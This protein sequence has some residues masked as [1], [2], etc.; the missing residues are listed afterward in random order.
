MALAKAAFDYSN[1][2]EHVRQLMSKYQIDLLFI[3]PSASLQYLTGLK[4]HQPTYGNVNY[5][6]GWV[7]GALFGQNKAPILSL[8]RMATLF[9]SFPSNLE[10]AILQDTAD[11][12]A[13]MRKLL[14]SFGPIKRLAIEERTWGSAILNLQKLLP[15]VEFVSA[16]PLLT[17]LRRAKSPAEIE[18]MRKAAKIID[19]THAHIVPM[20]R[21]GVTY[22]EVSAEIDKKMTELGAEAQSFPTTLI[23][24]SP[25]IGPGADPWAGSANHTNGSPIIEAG[26]SLSFD[27]GS[28][29][30]G[31][32]NDYGR[33]VWIGEPPA[34]YLKI[35]DLVIG[36]QAAARKAMKA[37][38][39]TGEAANTVA[40]EVI[41]GSGYGEYFFHRLGH[42]IGLDVH[43]PCYLSEGDTT[44]LQA[45]MTFT[46]EP[47]IFI[48]GKFGARIE[49][50]F[51]VTENGAE[52]LNQYPRN[53]EVVN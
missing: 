43:E 34:E 37:G 4:R 48:P 13:H 38:T 6:G 50:V 22:L 41:D 25:R 53:L 44:L 27:Y 17:E 24:M 39:I 18:L 29:F 47:S 5:N 49:D 20:L 26:T 11:P 40:R 52:P 28:V 31:Y 12:E 3:P 33:S 46:I 16:G 1:R 15:G 32:C 51:V 10:L 45:G 30:D 36:A 8:P 42:G 2:I 23:P 9:A 7:H 19:D 14:N 21:P 35:Y